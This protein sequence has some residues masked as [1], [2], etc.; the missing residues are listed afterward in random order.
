MRDINDTSY[1]DEARRV[2]LVN[3]LSDELQNALI[4]YDLTTFSEINLI[5]LYTRVD[6][7]LRAHAALSRNSRTPRNYDGT[8]KSATPATPIGTTTTT[9]TTVADPNAMDLSAGAAAVRRSPLSAKEKARRMAASLYLY[10]STARHRAIACPKR[11]KTL[12]LRSATVDVEEEGK[13]KA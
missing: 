6:A 8:F 11:P 2:A 12:A 1:N 4:T 5:A 9:T 10:C 7:R 3:G 13:E